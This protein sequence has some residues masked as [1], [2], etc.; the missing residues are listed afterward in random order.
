MKKK[1]LVLIS[2]MVMATSFTVAC[3][4]DAGNAGNTES[5]SVSKT[6]VLQQAIAACVLYPELANEIPTITEPTEVTEALKGYDNLTKSIEDILGTSISDFSGC[7]I[8]IIGNTK[9][10]VE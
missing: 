6:A 10:T 9:V 1:L 5:D 4:N 8:T 7:K 2:V 3:G